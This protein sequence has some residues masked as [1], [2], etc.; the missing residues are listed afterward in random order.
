MPRGLWLGLL[1]LAA[2]FVS[3][4]DTLSS[5]APDSP[6]AGVLTLD[7]GATAA[8]RLMN[9][10]TVVDRQS[11]ASTQVSFIQRRSLHGPLYWNAGFFGELYTFSNAHDFPLHQLQGYAAQFSIEYFRKAEPAAY[12]KIRPGFYFENRPVLS[13]WDVPVEAVSG[14]PLR[15]D[16]NGVIGFSNGRF[17]HHAFPIV[18]LTWLIEE[19]VQLNALYP[20][21][22][23]SFQPGENL[24]YKLAGQL[25]GDG[26]KTDSSPYA[27]R[28]EYHEYRIGGWVTFRLLPEWKVS[29]GAGVEWR[30]V[31]DFYRQGARL[32]TGGSP[33]IHLGLEYSH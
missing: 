23:V 30:R 21:P 33:F 29:G 24:E 1:V 28:V 4:A 16:L 9:G 2:S 13:A 27:S 22:S 26:F 12:L 18:G 25:T 31:F 11:N 20:E 8:S 17:Y 7:L 15:P 6:P 32:D 19:R 10:P 5:G 14:I 3:A